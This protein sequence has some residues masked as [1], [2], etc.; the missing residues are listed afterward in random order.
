VSDTRT[1]SHHPGRTI[2]IIAAMLMVLLGLTVLVWRLNLGLPGEIISLTIGATKAILV[3][4]Y[5]MN[6]RRAPATI[7]LAVLA[8]Y[9]WLALLLLGTLS[10]YLTRYR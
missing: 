2:A 4:W 3:A 5:F 8:G 7:R 10:D 6:V 1:R 9:F